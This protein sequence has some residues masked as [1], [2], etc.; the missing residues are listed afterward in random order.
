MLTNH[1][2]LMYNEDLPF[3]NLQRLIGHKRNQTKSYM[4]IYV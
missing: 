3:N 2:Y 4:G 1:V